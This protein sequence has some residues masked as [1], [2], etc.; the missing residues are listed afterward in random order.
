MEFIRVNDNMVKCLVTAEDMDQYDVSIEDFFTRS[1]NALELLHEIVRQ[2]SEEVG[3][4]PQGPLTSLQIAPI[5]EQG[6]AI[7]LTEKPQ[8]DLQNLLNNLKNHA[9]TF[10]PDD[11]LDMV[12]NSTDEERAELFSKFMENI[13]KEIEKGFVQGNSVPPR[14]EMQGEVS[15]SKALQGVENKKIGSKPDGSKQDEAKNDRSFKEVL[16]N[17]LR[18]DADGVRHFVSLDRKI[19][20]FDNISDLLGYAKAVELPGVVGSSLYKD[21][22][23]GT[24][25]LI[26]DRN[27]A[28]AGTLAG[29]YLTAYEYGH[30]VS[31]KAE[32]AYFIKEHCDCIIEDNAI[33]KLKG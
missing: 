3:Y 6:L 7:F 30:F 9:G 10:I 25:Y 17:A 1:E 16:D 12:Q 32:H 28:E 19:F 4:K 21:E 33:V 15:D 29:V 8:F 31:E 23:H 20:A 22:D 2:A 11:V 18:A 27:D 14:K 24:Y 5:E 13:H 26:V